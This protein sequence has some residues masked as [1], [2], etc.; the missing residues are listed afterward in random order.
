VSNEKE[1]WRGRQWK[2]T[3][4]GMTTLDG[5]DYWIEKSR[6]GDVRKHVT[7]EGR[8]ISD[9]MLHMAEKNWVDI[10]D[11]IAAWCVAV[12]VHN[13][14]V[15]TIDMAKSI[16]KARREKATAEAHERALADGW[17]SYDDAPKTSAEWAELMKRQSAGVPLTTKEWL[18]RKFVRKEQD[19]E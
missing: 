5:S 7:K 14:R 11:F 8:D 3:P 2:V 18:D 4:T 6:L 10:D 1:L 13:V 9:W 15:D 16:R 19:D 17:H 12:A